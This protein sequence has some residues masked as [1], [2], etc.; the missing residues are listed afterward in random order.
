M[1]WYNHEHR[2]SG[3]RDVSPAQHHAGDDRAILKARHA[4]YVQARERTPSRWSRTTRD[5]SSIG[6]VTLNPERETAVTACLATGA[7]KQ[8][9]A[10]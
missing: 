1:H 8:R 9:M 4:L 6:A 5:W 2:H 10:S 7:I 3:I